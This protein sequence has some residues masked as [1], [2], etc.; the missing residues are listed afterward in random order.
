MKK[1]HLEIN[2]YDHRAVCL[3]PMEKIIEDE[4]VLVDDFTGDV[5]SP[6]EMCNDCLAKDL[7][8]QILKQIV[9]LKGHGITPRAVLFHPHGVFAARRH[10]ANEMHKVVG[11][12][13]DALPI[14]HK[15]FRWRDLLV[16]ERPEAKIWEAE[17][18]GRPRKEGESA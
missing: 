1:F 8:R 15:G 10:L 4:E 16:V 3:K 12:Y 7:D 13:V 6:I 14:D 17:V 9:E 18:W 11:L 5:I 2:P